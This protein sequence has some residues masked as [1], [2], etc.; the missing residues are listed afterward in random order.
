MPA[1]PDVARAERITELSCVDFRIEGDGTY[2]PEIVLSNGCGDVVFWRLCVN[3]RAQLER[4]YFEGALRP[5]ETTRIETFPVEGEEFYAGG[6][7]Q[8]GSDVVRAPQC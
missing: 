6:W 5:G 1:G 7:A 2:N 4:E 8:T 3:Y